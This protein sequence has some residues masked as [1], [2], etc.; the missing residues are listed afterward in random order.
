[1]RSSTVS[2]SAR[3]FGVAVGEQFERALEIGEEDRD[4]LALAGQPLAG[5]ADFAGEMRG[6]VRGGRLCTCGVDAAETGA[7]LHAEFRLGDVIVLA[8]GTLHSRLRSSVAR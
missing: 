5:A 2:S 7:A 1:M 8:A 4:L 6:R 3:V